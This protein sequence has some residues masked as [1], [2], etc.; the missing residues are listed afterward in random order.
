MPIHTAVS[1]GGFIHPDTVR[2][3][4][5]NGKVWAHTA[6]PCLRGMPLDSSFC[7]RDT[8]CGVSFPATARIKEQHVPPP[9]LCPANNK[10][11]GS[12]GSV[13]WTCRSVPDP[14]GA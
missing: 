6:T 3:P 9:P 8:K 1:R 10:E 5:I 12:N 11:Y 13:R 2:Q 7:R 14:F 4:L